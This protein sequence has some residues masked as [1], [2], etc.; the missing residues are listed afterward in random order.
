VLG[1]ER[2]AIEPGEPVS[3]VRYGGAA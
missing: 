3:V 2:V 1:P